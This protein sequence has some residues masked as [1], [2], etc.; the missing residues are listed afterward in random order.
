MG[1][2]KQEGVSP[3]KFCSQFYPVCVIKKLWN[4][5][6]N[7]QNIV[8]YIP[9]NLDTFQC[10]EQKKSSAAYELKKFMTNYKLIKMK[11][12][13][14]VNIPLVINA[15]NSQTIQKGGQSWREIS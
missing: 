10:Q 9:E 14:T 7:Y 2:G 8:F 5:G 4:A 3:H 13:K 12:R 1:F 11:K 15:Y 6:L